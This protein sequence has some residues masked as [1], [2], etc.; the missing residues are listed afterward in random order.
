MQRSLQ[1]FLSHCPQSCRPLH[2]PPVTLQ[3]FSHLRTAELLPAL[4]AAPFAWEDSFPLHTN[5]GKQS[6]HS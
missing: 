1:S 4:L 2:L 5:R 3:E 6:P